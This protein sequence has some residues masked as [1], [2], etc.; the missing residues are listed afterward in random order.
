MEIEEKISVVIVNYNAG[1]GLV[2]STRAAIADAHEVIVVDNDSSD[3]SLQLLESVLGDDPKIRIVRSC[4]NE[5]FAKA[6]NRGVAIATGE[7]I[8]FLNPDCELEKGAMACLLEAIQADVDVGMVGGLLL[9]PDGSEQA[10]GRRAIPTPW[11]SFVRAFGLARFSKRWPKLFFDFH[12]HKE[13]LPKSPIE[14]EAISGACMLVRR[15][16]MQEIGLL[17]EEYFM[18]CE[19]LDWCIRFRRGEWKILFVPGAKMLHHKGVCSRARP[20]FVEWHKHKGMMRFYR[21]LFRHQYPGVLMWLV[22]VGVWLRFFMVAIYYTTRR[23]GKA[24][25][26]VRD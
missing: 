11:R 16:A 17:D 14:V 6:C 4:F 10:G 21:K 24:F 25:G 8:F 23:M 13:P 20:V 22:S 7:F 2:E 5:G 19:D 3:G 12:L 15:K 1:P 18:H 26:F 9:N